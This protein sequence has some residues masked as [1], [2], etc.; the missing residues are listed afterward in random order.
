VY[1]EFIDLF[2]LDRLRI[3]RIPGIMGFNHYLR[4]AIF[5]EHVNLPMLDPRVLA[6]LHKVF[7][8]IYLPESGQN[9]KI[10]ENMTPSQIRDLTLDEA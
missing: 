3:P 10:T 5:R 2:Y 8:M 6:N 4:F 9:P 7:D 1:K